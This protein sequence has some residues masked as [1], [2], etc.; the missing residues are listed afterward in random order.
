MGIVCKYGYEIK[1]RAPECLTVYGIWSFVGM[2]ANFVN[3]TNSKSMTNIKFQCGK[4][5]KFSK[6]NDKKFR[7]LTSIDCECHADVRV[8][9]RSQRKCSVFS[10][11]C[12]E[13]EAEVHDH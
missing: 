5:G 1:I 4:V 11:G 6:S 2:Y 8:S 12:A 13:L 10:F 3:A 9:T 7:K